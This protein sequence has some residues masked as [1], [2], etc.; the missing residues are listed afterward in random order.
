M[1]ANHR[2][3]A[4]SWQCAGGLEPDR[5]RARFMA[6]K[7][8]FVSVI[9]HRSK[10]GSPANGARVG[11]QPPR[12]SP[13]GPLCQS[14][15][16]GAANPR[17]GTPGVYSDDRIPGA[18]RADRWRSDRS[19]PSTSTSG[20]AWRSRPNGSIVGPSSAT[21]NGTR[22]AN[23]PSRRARVVGDI[24]VTRSKKVESPFKYATTC[25]RSGRNLICKLP[26]F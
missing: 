16:N 20:R 26:G 9:V 13:Q 6:S 21:T 19:R 8:A 4:R 18:R 11:E 17:R 1:R 14:G 22:R 7:P 23:A 10:E 5:Q 15:P 24:L 2:C 3:E 12:S 25:T